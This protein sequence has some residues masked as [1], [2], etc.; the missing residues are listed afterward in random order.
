[1][2]GSA[3]VYGVDGTAAYGTVLIG[4]NYMQSCNVTD[5]VDTAEARDER[6]NVFGYNL[7]NFRR[8]ANFE[9][10][11][12]GST[13]VIA[14][15]AVELPVPGAI[16]TIAQNDDGSPDYDTLPAILVGGWNY[17]G[18]GGIAMSNTDLLR[19]TLPCSR[20][21]TDADGGGTPTAM[22]GFAH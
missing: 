5:E 18:G 8:T 1:M 15:A 22:Q 19:M 4:E 11:F 7:Y 3:T 6:G 14:A 16:V 12:Y 17:I 2:V 10:I 13:E 9:I 20:Y 21:N